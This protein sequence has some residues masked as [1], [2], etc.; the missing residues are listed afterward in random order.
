MIIKMRVFIQF[1]E[2]RDLANALKLRNQVVS[3][4]IGKVICPNENSVRNLQ[5][6]VKQYL[7]E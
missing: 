1:K 6:K 3:S 4:K 5:F 7:G 2:I